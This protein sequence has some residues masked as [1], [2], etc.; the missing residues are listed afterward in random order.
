VAALAAGSMTGRAARPKVPFGQLKKDLPAALDYGA[1]LRSD[2][3]AWS[4]GNGKPA[5]IA[6]IGEPL[7]GANNGRK[8]TW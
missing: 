4:A 3:V 8:C 6:P 7:M 2:P 1:I 5:P